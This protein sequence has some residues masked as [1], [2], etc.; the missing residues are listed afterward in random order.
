MIK[1]IKDDLMTVVSGLIVTMIIAGLSMGIVA[2]LP[3]DFVG[4]TVVALFIGM[5][6]GNLWTLPEQVKPGVQFAAKRLLKVFIILLGAS[7]NMALIAEVGVQALILLAFTIGTAF[8]AGKLLGKF[9]GTSSE[10]SA[11]LSAGVAICGG[12]AISALSPVIEAEEEETTYAISTVFLF[13]MVLIILFP[14]VGQLL[15]FSDQIM[16][17]WSGTA[18]NDTSSVVAASFAF[19]A[20]AGAIATTVKLTRTLGIIPVVLTYGALQSRE[21]DSWQQTLGRVFPWFIVLFVGL[22]LANTVG[23]IP[24]ELGAPLNDLRKFLMVTALAGVGLKT[25][26]NTIRTVGAKPFLHAL[27][28]S[29]AVIVIAIVVILGLIV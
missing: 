22:A 11:L 2:L 10:L 3:V 7:M 15:G 18:I 1:K 13:D 6:V 16:G 28:L 23:W 29:A 26:L 4:A 12:S 24:E 27:I 9:F 20:G 8:I 17:F 14:L 25:D 19:S 21:G 5:L